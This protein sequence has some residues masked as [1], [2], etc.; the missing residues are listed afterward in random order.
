MDEIKD[1]TFPENDP[2]AAFSGMNPPR[3]FYAPPQLEVSIAEGHSIDELPE[4]FITKT[5]NVNAVKN[6][7]MFGAPIPAILLYQLVGGSKM[8][9]VE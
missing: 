5:I 8:C 4:Q 1:S 3:N 7:I 9:E 6:A 2:L